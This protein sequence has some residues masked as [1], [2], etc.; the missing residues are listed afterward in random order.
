MSQLQNGRI[1]DIPAGP[2]GIVSLDGSREFTS[3][4]NEKIVARRRELVE[5]NPDLLNFKGFLRDNYQISITTN[6]FASGEGKVVINETI[7][8]YDIYI[9]ADIGN[10]SAT[11]TMYGSPQRMSPDDHYQDIK[12][13]I[14]AIGGKAR[15]INVIM[16]LLYES[17]QHKRYARESL[18]CAM[19]L[20]ELMRLGVS[21]II[22]F[23]AHDPRVQNAIPLEG[24]ESLY[25]HYQLI[26]ALLTAV[27]DLG[28][29]RDNMAVVSPDEGGMER[30]I[31]YA[32]I[33]GL[34]LGMFYKRRDYTRVINGR[35]PII[36]HEYL[37]DDLSG[38]DILIVDDVISSGESVLEI[39][40]ELKNC[41]ARRIFILVTFAQ[42]T[43]G[44]DEFDKAYREGVITRLLATNLTYRTPQLL[45]AP[46]YVD[47]DA[48]KFLAHLIETLN[49]DGSISPLINPS[50]KI[51]ALVAAYRLK[52]HSG[53]TTTMEVS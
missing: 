29:H 37:G 7:R 25:A 15:R 42:F 34:D 49:H 27:P 12:R 45:A 51:K 24:F 8:G 22:T 33:L 13:V 9:L 46:W 19:A 44:I 18:D 6:R 16:P 3:L 21:N 40:R 1:W 10:F 53:Q 23:D 36:R 43:Q 52:Q 26:K 41:G 28:I 50:E 17:R 39:A 2:L 31:Y 4:V 48:S 5:E 14:G 20:Q 32:G 38:K 47:A 30:S 11:Y 35:N